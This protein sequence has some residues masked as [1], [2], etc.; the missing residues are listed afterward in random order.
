[1]AVVIVNDSAIIVDFPVLLLDTLGFTDSEFV[2]ICHDADGQ[3]V[4]AVRRPADAAAIIAA[5]PERANIYFGVNPIRGPVRDRAGRGT[6]ADV[7]RLSALWADLDVKP[8]GCA[9]LDTARTIINDLSS[10]LGTR[11]S[12]IT[13]SGGGLHPY[14][15][16]SDGQISGNG[17]GKAQALVR[18]WGRL[19]AIVAE[20]HGAKT[21]SVYDLARVLRVPGTYN[22]KAPR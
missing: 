6:A 16:V 15:P 18:R 12:V 9:D 5:L 19:V 13:H 17:V 22:R 20:Q 14:W 7:T 2:S 4:T 11:P 8:G 10:I 1:V 21:D 3:F